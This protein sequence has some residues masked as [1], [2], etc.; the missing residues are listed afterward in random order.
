LRGR[1]VARF[2]GGDS[3]VNA[4]RLI[5]MLYLVVFVGVAGASGIYFWEARAEYLQL[6]EQEEASRRRLAETEARL[7]EQ[8]KTLERLRHDPVY[9]EKVIRRRLGYARPDEFIFRFEE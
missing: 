3:A 9:V 7:Q 1:N 6:R 8:E 5:V 2:T 4:R